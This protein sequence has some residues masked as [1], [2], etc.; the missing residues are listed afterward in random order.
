MRDEK[1]NE[2]LEDAIICH[3]LSSQRAIENTMQFS[4]HWYLRV[5]SKK[6][7]DIYRYNGM[8]LVLLLINSTETEYLN[9][10]D[11]IG[12]KENRKDNILFG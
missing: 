11:I 8:K 3:C 1:N 10:E 2:D 12:S 7:L 9:I 4:F 6:M 5:W